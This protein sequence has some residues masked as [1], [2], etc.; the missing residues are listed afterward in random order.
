MQN[1][2]DR[3]R[4]EHHHPWLLEF[5]KVWYSHNGHRIPPS[6]A[7]R[8]LHEYPPDINVHP[9]SLIHSSFLCY[10]WL[11]KRPSLCCFKDWLKSTAPELTRTYYS[12]ASREPHIQVVRTLYRHQRVRVDMLRWS[13]RVCVLAASFSTIKSSRDTISMPSFVGKEGQT[14]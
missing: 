4:Q 5:T 8:E 14:I 13:D 2:V 11:P 3:L 9:Y 1:T 12:R 10:R 7:H 6:R